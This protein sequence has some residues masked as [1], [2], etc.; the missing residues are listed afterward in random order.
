MVSLRKVSFYIQSTSKKIAF[1]TNKNVYEISGLWKRL[2]VRLKLPFPLHH[3][4]KTQMWSFICEKKCILFYEL[5]E[6]REE[7]KLY[8]RAD[9]MDEES[10]M[11][12][13]PVSFFFYN[14]L[15][16]L[17]TLACVG[18]QAIGKW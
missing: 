4:F 7:L 12:L 9:L 3:I 17:V 10:G 6:E 15:A 16:V 2:S 14:I 1:Q 11:P 18:T 13:E 5:P 8:D